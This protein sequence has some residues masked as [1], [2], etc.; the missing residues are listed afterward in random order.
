MT[1]KASY[2]PVSPLMANKEE[3]RIDTETHW[4]ASPF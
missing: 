1:S 3:I 2:D 4:S